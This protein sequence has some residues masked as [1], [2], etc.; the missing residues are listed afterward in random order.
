[1]KW[2]NSEAVP[3]NGRVV[4]ILEDHPK[5]IYPL[6]YTIHA[7][8]VCHMTDGSIWRVEHGDETGCGWCLWYPWD[9]RAWCYAEEFTL[10]AEILKN[11]PDYHRMEQNVSDYRMPP[12]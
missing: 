8:E 10:V 5:E 7:G 11:V 1:M 2:H 12:Q 9:I 6:S 4:W 3:E